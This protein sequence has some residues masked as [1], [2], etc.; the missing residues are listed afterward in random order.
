MMAGEGGELGKEGSA[1]A[2]TKGFME[3]RRKRG[4]SLAVYFKEESDV[5]TYLDESQQLALDELKQ[6]LHA[7]ING[8]FFKPMKKTAEKAEPDAV[9]D[10][11]F[12]WGVSLSD[13]DKSDAVL[14]K[15]LRARDF[16]VK[17]SLEMI[18]NTVIWREEFGVEGLL[19]E[20]LGM[21]ELD[22]VAFMQGQDKE[23]HPVC[24]N[25][26]GEF[27]DKDLYQKVFTDE[28][29]RKRFLRWRI[30]FLEKGIREHL[31]FSP[32]GICS[33]TQVTDLKNSPVLAR[34]EL[35][36]ATKQ[37]LAVFQDNYPEFV[38]KNVRNFW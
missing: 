28:E 31:D 29:K 24:Y 35:R 1:A 6:L 4:I 16:K 7:A 13:D 15:F 34:R 17:E 10:E 2:E 11:F 30:Q 9:M 18:K 5:V 19:D 37:A 26:Y 25:V 33:M 23:G 20:D 3:G 22:K 32:R 8:D 36:Q 21:K 27:Q 38:A 12:L 14:L